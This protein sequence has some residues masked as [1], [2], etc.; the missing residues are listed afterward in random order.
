[1]FLLVILRIN[2]SACIRKAENQLIDIK[3]VLL[4]GYKI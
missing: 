1:M 2:N 3:I 4:K